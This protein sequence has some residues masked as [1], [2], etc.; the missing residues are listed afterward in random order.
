MEYLFI[1]LFIVLL[2]YYFF[3]YTN[4]KK[5][6]QKLEKQKD[7]IEQAVHLF[8]GWLNSKSYFRYRKCT[9]WKDKFQLLAKIVPSKVSR[10]PLSAE[11][12]NNSKLFQRFYY[13]ADNLRNQHNAK[14]ITDE[15]N[16]CKILFGN[17]ENYPLTLKQR[18]AIVTDEDNNLI[19]AGAGTGKTSTLIGKI[20]YLLKRKRIDPSKILVLAFTRKAS[21]EIKERVRSKTNVEM[22]I[23]TFHKFGLDII[24]SVEDKKP[25]LAFADESGDELRRFIETVHQELLHQTKYQVLIST[26]FLSYL[27][28]YKPP[29]K[30]KNEGD[31]FKE[32]KSHR[33]LKGETLRS[34]E[35]IEIANFLFVNNIDY[36]YE[37]EYEVN[38]AN[39]NYAQYKPDFYLPKY[40]IYIEHFGLIDRAGN[41]PHW[42]SSKRGF[43]AKTEYNESIKW[44]REIHR[45]NR[46]ILVETFSYEKKEGNLLD[47][48]KSR[49]QKHDVKFDATPIQIVKHF[50]DKNEFP[51]FINL[52]ITF[53][54]L[55]KSNGFGIKELYA[56][57]KERKLI[58][59]E[60][61]LEVFEPI[62]KKYQMHLRDKNK[63]DFSDML[64]K[65]TEYIKTSKY[66]SQYEY[67]LV[68]EFQD[69]SVGRYKLISNLISQNP[70]QSLFCVGDDWQSIYRFTGSDISI[71]TEFEK[72][73]GFTKRVDLDLTFRLNDKVTEFTQNFILKNP[74]QLKKNLTSNNISTLEPFKI[75]YETKNIDSDNNQD[76]LESCLNLIKVKANAGK[77][78][79]FILGRYNFDEPKTLQFIKRKYKSLD[80]NFMTA[81]SSKGLEADYVI[82]INANSGK[83]GFPSEI[84]DDPI[85]TLVLKIQDE[86]ENAEERRLFYVALTRTRNNIYIICNQN[87]PSKFVN[88]LLSEYGTVDRCPQCKSG[89]LVKRNNPK[90]KSEF[91]GCENF[92]LCTYTKNIN[93]NNFQRSKKR[94]KMHR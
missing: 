80:I 40:K 48:L 36:I 61:F 78:K 47:L 49:L 8:D 77:E 52:I 50:E 70:E 43:S 62:F 65:A 21:D 94:F 74:K 71:M 6:A 67:I 60:K 11:I 25:S 85:L 56:I 41:V 57:A 31:Y 20:I 72:Y 37:K 24:S 33:T 45:K 82:I 76:T 75:V 58:R 27:K 14:Y 68:D 18:E 15:I 59:E 10:L 42:F 16:A 89:L 83:Y 46:T 38:T 32:L 19:I 5:L 17:I 81:H 66:R 91:W 55:M 88:E 39:R 28:P 64:I 84:V 22:D 7:E 29:E 73:F 2:A 86:I 69:M 92:P 12:K 44:K 53:L 13:N 90:D 35:E 93:Y 54:N 1:I 9:S 51:P 63:I 26:Y 30:Y 4:Q 87:I 23:K 34:F 79:V 3:Y